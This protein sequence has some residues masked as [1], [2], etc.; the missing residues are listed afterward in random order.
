MRG[1]T[2]LD[3]IDVCEK[4]MLVMRYVGEDKHFKVFHQHTG[5]SATYTFHQ[6]PPPTLEKPFNWP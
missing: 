5:F 1:K 6:P 2:F 4:S 3:D